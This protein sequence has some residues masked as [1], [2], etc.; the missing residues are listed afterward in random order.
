MSELLARSFGRIM[1]PVTATLVPE[2]SA[3]AIWLGITVVVSL[4]ACAWP[5][6]RATRIPTVAALAYE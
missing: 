4:A 3:V 5:G 1:L 6:I 2:W